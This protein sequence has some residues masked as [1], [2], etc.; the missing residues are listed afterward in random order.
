MTRS[1]TDNVVAALGKS[2]HVF[3]VSLVDFAG[4]QLE[5]VLAAM[6]VP[7]P[8]L[9]DL[10]LFSNGDTMPVI[11]DSFLSGFAPRL[12]HFQLDGIPFPGLPK[13]LLSATHLVR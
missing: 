13:L 10:L 8:V 6:Q 1:G 4:S 7:F 11:P 2:N 3:E 5:Q 9:T 12:R